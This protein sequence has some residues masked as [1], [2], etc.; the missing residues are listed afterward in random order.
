MFR[1]MILCVH[2][3]YLKISVMSEIVLL[4]YLFKN[5]SYNFTRLA[6]FWLKHRYSKILNVLMMNIVWPIFLQEFFRRW[7]FIILNALQAYLMWILYFV[8]IIFLL[9]CWCKSQD[10]FQAVLFLSQFQFAAMR[11]FFIWLVIKSTVWILGEGVPW[12][13]WC[14]EVEGKILKK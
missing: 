12:L 10:E 2:R 7:Q 13:N 3:G 14:A 5:I 11:I 8:V 9:T 4:C 6:M 1:T